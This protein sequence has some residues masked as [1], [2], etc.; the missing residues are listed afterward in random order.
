[1]SEPHELDKLTRMVLGLRMISFFILVLVLTIL[2]VALIA[3]WLELG[4]FVAVGIAWFAMGSLF[5]WG[6]KLIYDDKEMR[7]ISG[8]KRKT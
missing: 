1:M 6:T 2:T 8:R 7:E 4:E 3:G 5:M